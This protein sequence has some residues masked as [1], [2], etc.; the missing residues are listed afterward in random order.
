MWV[1]GADGVPGLLPCWRIPKPPQQDR[2]FGPTSG[3][4]DSCLS[5]AGLHRAEALSAEIQ[6]FP[7]QRS[8]K[9]T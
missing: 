6:I 2:A 4:Q 9:L 3:F 1:G 5:T 7:W 8:L